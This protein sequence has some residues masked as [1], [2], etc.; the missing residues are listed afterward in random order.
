MAVFPWQS[1]VQDQDGNAIA[2][3]QLTIR[4]GTIAGA[5]A[6]I[7]SDS[8]E[9]PLANPL[10]ATSDGFAQ[11][12]AASGTYYIEAESGGQTTDGWY[13]VLGGAATGIPV[14]LTA[15]AAAGEAV[16]MDGALV[17]EATTAEYLGLAQAAGVA[18]DTI[19]VQSTGNFTLGTWAWTPDEY[20]YLTNAGALTQT[21]PTGTHRRIGIATTSTVIALSAGPVVVETGGAG[22][23]NAIPALDDAGLL[24][25]T[26]IEKAAT[27]GAGAENLL[28]QADAGGEIDV[29]FLGAVV[30]T[31]RQLT[32]S[33]ALTAGDAVAL[34]A[35]D[36]VEAVGV[37]AGVFSFTEQTAS[38]ALGS[39][40]TSSDSAYD[41]TGGIICHAYIDSTTSDVTVSLGI[42]T[43]TS[44]TY[45]ADTVIAVGAFAYVSV[46]HDPVNNVFIL[47]YSGSSGDT[48]V[49]AFDVSG[50][51]VGT[52]GSAVSVRAQQCFFVSIAA[53]SN[54]V[55]FAAVYSVFAA[56]VYAR[57]GSISGTT[58]TLGAEVTI[59]TNSNTASGIV[60]D[61]FTGNYVALVGDNTANQIRSYV[62]TPT[63]TTLS[64]GAVVNIQESITPAALLHGVCSTG[65]QL[66][67]CCPESAS[68]YKLATGTISGTTCVWTDTGQTFGTSGTARFPILGYNSIDDEFGAINSNLNASGG[69]G[70]EYSTFTVTGGIITEGTINKL[71]GISASVTNTQNTIR[72]AFDTG[73]GV[74]CT[75][76][77]QGSPT[78]YEVVIDPATT[79]TNA[80]S[81]IGFSQTTVADTETVDVAL[82]GDIN[83]DQTGLT[84][85]T[86]YFIASDGTLSAVDTG[87]GKVGRALSATEILVTKNT[88]SA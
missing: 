59:N 70:F 83:A 72:M 39:S 15:T 62:L 25:Y 29:S 28:V 53:A 67:V 4:E 14:E 68:L 45:G 55:Q 30:D 50:T 85:G 84:F 2:S 11:F 21:P 74:Y 26:M 80:L 23:E 7:F 32:A 66:L 71:T 58:I 41:A 38:V 33:G 88:W 5:V 54:G 36:T 64:V 82:L 1:T 43:G 69:A 35:A 56:T 6:T 78:M 49:R 20:V 27:G 18:T 31:S 8:A 10:N 13:V 75:L 87:F 46:T 44:V 48:L 34:S 76:V 17:S 86:D 73:E 12:W 81:F 63:V 60:Y 47:I 3:A 52:I 77:K 9:T 79:R 24:D 57:A 65:G 61:P 40:P 22:S 37:T 42:A 51:T 16:S 19:N